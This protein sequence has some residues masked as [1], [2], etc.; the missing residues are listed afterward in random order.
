MKKPDSAA[1][2]QRNEGD[3]MTNEQN[4]TGQYSPAADLQPMNFQRK[5][6]DGSKAVYE[7]RIDNP[8]A[9]FTLT[10]TTA[11]PGNELEVR[12]IEDF[13][14]D[15]VARFEL[16]APISVENPDYIQEPESFD[17]S[18]EILFEPGLVEVRTGTGPFAIAMTLQTTVGSDDVEP[19]P[20]EVLAIRGVVLAGKNH[21]YTA[22]NGSATATVTG[23]QGRGRISSPNKDISTGGRQS[24]SGRTVTVHGY[25]RFLYNLSGNFR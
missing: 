9:T 18:T 14:A 5:S 20:G 7:A 21:T 25:T 8:D 6:D 1:S 13:L 2:R 3:E 11:S 4:G 12:E 24:D 16:A 15:M 19:P 23:L 17:L 10:V 22:R